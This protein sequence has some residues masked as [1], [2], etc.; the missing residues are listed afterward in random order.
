[1]PHGEIHILV[2]V[3][4][5]EDNWCASS[6]APALAPPHAGVCTLKSSPRPADRSVVVL[7]AR[8]RRICST[9]C[10]EKGWALVLLQ[11][12]LPWKKIKPELPKFVGS[13]SCRRECL[14]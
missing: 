3:S 6:L 2:N 10:A 5:L 12:C 11:P 9:N 7:G 14:L 13:S 1:V 8:W 4:V